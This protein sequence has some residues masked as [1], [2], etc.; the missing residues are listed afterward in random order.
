L[1]RP[2]RIALV[3]NPFRFKNRVP[4]HA[5]ELARELLGRGHVVRGFGATP[6]AIPRSGDMGTSVQ[7]DPVVSIA[8]FVPDVLVAYDALSPAAARAAR[9]ASKINVP[10]FLVEEALPDRGRRLERAVRWLGECL[11]GSYVRRRA[12]RVIALD[13]VARTQAEEEGFDPE[14]IHVLPGG[15]NL[16]HYRP[17]LT[18]PLPTQHGIRGRILLHLGRLDHGRG[19]EVLVEAFAHTVGRREGW[20]LVMAGTGPAAHHLRAQASR[21]GIGASVCWLRTPRE[22]ELPGLLAASTLLVSPCL[23][24]DVSGWRVRRALACGLPVLA[25]RGSRSEEF[26]EHDGW[27]LLIDKQEEAGWE[28]ALTVATGSPER[29]RRW[30]VAAREQAEERYAWPTIVKD[31]EALMLGEL[32]QSESEGTAIN[33]ADGS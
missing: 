17:D 12:S 5:P 22:E 11:W 4:Q 20:T 7:A 26:V 23:E 25:G 24:D 33:P 3:V 10:L 28:E 21:L 6:G 29:R 27:G 9:C 31:F 32:R 1:P 30:G 14:R 13:A 18:S 19:L 2:L 16:G 8:R 15:V